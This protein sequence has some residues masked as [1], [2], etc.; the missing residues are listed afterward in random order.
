MSGTSTSMGS[1]DEYFPP[2]L[3]TFYNTLFLNQTKQST[4]SVN[5]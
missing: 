5:K 4:V 2:I 3:N 1:M